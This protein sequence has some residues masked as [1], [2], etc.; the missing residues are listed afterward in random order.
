MYVLPPPDQLKQLSLGHRAALAD[1]LWTHVLV[2]QGLRVKERR[3]FETLVPLLEAIIELD[4]EFRRPYLLADALITFQ[5]SE[6]PFEEVIKAREIMVRGTENRPYDAEIW[7]V[8]GQFVAFIAPSY[9]DDQGRPG[10]MAD[11]WCAIPGSRG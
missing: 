8:L 2:A 11:R 10:S 1:L 9:T 5:A 6:T 7:L 3:R 4:P